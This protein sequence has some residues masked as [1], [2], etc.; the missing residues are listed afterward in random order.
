MNNELALHRR[1]DGMNAR[2]CLVIG[3]GKSAVRDQ[4]QIGTFSGIT[5]LACNRAIE[6]VRAHY[7]VWVD[8]THYERSGWHPNAKMADWVVP[9]D[10]S[11]CTG[12]DVICY[13]IAR[14]LPCAKSELYLSGGTLTVAAHLAVRLGARR[15]V[16]RG[17]DAWG[18]SRDRYHYWD[19]MPLDGQGRATHRQH[20][21]KTAEGIRNLAR[22]YPD[23]EF[24]DATTG[25]RHLGLPFVRLDS[26]ACKRGGWRMAKKNEA[27]ILPDPSVP[28]GYGRLISV[29]A[30]RT[31]EAVMWFEDSSGTVRAVR[32][33]CDTSNGLALEMKGQ[34]L[35]ART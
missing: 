17:C 6:I 10:A 20:L 19:G 16:F 28:M 25:K 18:E 22:V 32:M 1:H 15:I 33:G 30:F 4:E 27:K 31:K 34:A 14:S 35:V 26:L 23:V 21:E 8:R 7:W 24:L 5:V 29:T 2:L 9:L 3:C 11:P 12:R 13:D